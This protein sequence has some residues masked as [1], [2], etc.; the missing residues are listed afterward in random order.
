[1]I[2]INGNII[3]VQHKCGGAVPRGGFANS[4]AA[5]IMAKVTRFRQLSDNVIGICYEQE[6]E[7]S[8]SGKISADIIGTEA[9][10]H[11]EKMKD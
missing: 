9:H 5:N 6:Y 10:N 11:G 1:M 8:H 3:P 7:Q 4:T 2:L